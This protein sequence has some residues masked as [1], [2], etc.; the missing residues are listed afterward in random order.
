MKVIDPAAPDA[1]QQAQAEVDEEAEARRVAAAKKDV[2]SWH[3]RVHHGREHMR[4]ERDRWARDRR[5]AASGAADPDEQRWEVEANL[6]GP[7]MEVILAFVYAKD[8][9]IAARPAESAGRANVKMIGKA[10]E[11][12]QIVVSRQLRDARLKTA[13]KRWVR[14]AMTV[15]IGWIFAGMQTR[16]EN[17]PVVEK[18][19]NDLTQNL[20]QLQSAEYIAESGCA[21]PDRAR[22]DAEAQIVALQSRMERQVANGVTLDVMKPEDVIVDPE[23]TEVEDYLAANWIA[24]DTYKSLY[25]AASLVIG[26]GDEAE[27]EKLLKTANRYMQKPRKGDASDPGTEPTA[28]AYEPMTGTDAEAESMDGFIRFTQIYSRRDGTV[29][30]MIDGITDRWARPQYSPKTWA[31]FYPLFGLSFHPID[32]LR[33][34]KSDVSALASLQEEYSRTRSNQALHRRRSIPGMVFDS[35]MVEPESV[36]ALQKATQQEYVAIKLTK[37]NIPVRDVFHHKPYN[38]IDPSLYDTSSTKQDMEQISGA[39]EALQSVTTVEKTA[40]EAEI[41]NTGFNA[42]TSARRD[43]VEDALSDL[44]NWCAQVSL[45]TLDPADAI[46]YAGPEAVWTKLTPDEAQTLFDIVILAGSTGKPKAKSD[47]DAW[48]TLLPLIQGMIGQI[49]AARQAGQEWAAEPLI[50]LLR[51]TMKRLDDPASIDDFLP[52]PPP[53]PPMI[54]PMTGMPVIDP[55]TGQPVPATPPAPMAPAA[56]AAAGQPV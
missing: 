21:D 32:G 34:A 36:D 49:G 20:R 10:C 45:Q 55:N 19:I 7:I 37:E 48:G 28:G 24:I 29:R 52:V 2:E 27:V 18:E 33:Y 41:Q 11:T 22:A 13:A 12:L 4:H 17:D 23:C 39:G 35:S 14:S 1:E 43:N 9:D 5:L 56:P 38:P 40:T 31:Q 6:I 8:P 54:D 51:E 44:A 3:K 30:T 47:R 15:G 46:R 50:A 42:R 53:P 25:D 26:W 16:K